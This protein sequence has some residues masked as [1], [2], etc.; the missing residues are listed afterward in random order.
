MQVFEANLNVF[1]NTNFAV[2]SVYAAIGIPRLSILLLAK[3][4]QKQAYIMKT[5]V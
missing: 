1:R 3:K 5:T 2:L 4:Q